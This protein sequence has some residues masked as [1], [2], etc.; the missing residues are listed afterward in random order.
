MSQEM[1]ETCCCCSMRRCEIRECVGEGVGESTRIG[2]KNGVERVVARKVN[3]VRGVEF[4][5][6]GFEK[7]CERRC[8]GV[9]QVGWDCLHS[10]MR[11]CVRREMMRD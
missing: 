3:A 11:R 1:N 9:E 4:G 5:R 6:E 7:G 2:G 10:P 8:A